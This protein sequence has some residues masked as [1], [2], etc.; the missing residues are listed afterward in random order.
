[1]R[2]LQ[3]ESWVVVADTA[4]ETGGVELGDLIRDLGVVGQRQEAVSEQVR[5]V[6]SPAVVSSQFDADGLQVG[7]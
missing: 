4:L 3:T 7:R 2:P 1:M 6:K 5:D